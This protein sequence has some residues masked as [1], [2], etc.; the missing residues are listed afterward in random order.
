MVTLF[1]QINLYTLNYCQNWSTATFLHAAT[2]YFVLACYDVLL[3]DTV[4][5]HHQ[6]LSD[7]TARGSSDPNSVPL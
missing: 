5:A 3:G 2:A 4:A 1:F 6:V 7:A